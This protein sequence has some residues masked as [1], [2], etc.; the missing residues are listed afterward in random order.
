VTEDELKCRTKRFA[1]RSIRLADSLP[2]KPGARAIANQLARCGPAV[3]AN[4]RAACR[5][6][7]KAEFIAKLGNVEEEADE[8]AYW[9]EMIIEAELAS[10]HLVQPLLKEAEASN[11]RKFHSL[12]SP[13]NHSQSKIQNPK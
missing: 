5:G 4:Y 2:N 1:L 8:S 9:M 3:G 7:S 6:R 10:T 11:Y 12:L 13:L